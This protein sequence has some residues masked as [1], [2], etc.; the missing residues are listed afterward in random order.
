MSSSIGAL[1]LF[2]VFAVFF[3]TRRMIG[4]KESPA[5]VEVG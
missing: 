3:R 4:K 5:L 2:L 1:A